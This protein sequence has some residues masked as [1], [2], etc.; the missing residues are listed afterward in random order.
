MP[1]LHEL[2]LTEVAQKIQS[3]EVSATEVT[4]HMLNR[5]E[6]LDGGLKSYATV[7]AEVATMQATEAD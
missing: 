6:R 7:M 4:A 3:R 2:T 1:D 5:I